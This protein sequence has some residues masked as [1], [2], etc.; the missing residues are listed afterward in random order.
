MRDLI[1]TIKKCFQNHYRHMILVVFAGIILVIGYYATKI[2]FD[3]SPDA[4]ALKKDLQ[5]SAYQKANLYFNDDEQLFI[6]INDIKPFESLNSIDALVREV[7]GINLVS[8][9]YAITNLPLLFSPRIELFLL[10]F[11][12]PTIQ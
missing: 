5:S 3:I 6:I 1:N 7:E 2:T 9:V 10:M 12:I 4:I 11:A 8:G